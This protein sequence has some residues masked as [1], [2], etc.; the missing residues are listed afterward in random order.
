MPDSKNHLERNVCSVAIM[1]FVIFKMVGVKFG[2]NLFFLF[3]EK[4]SAIQRL[5]VFLKSGV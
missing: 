2:L 1:M 3:L 5:F 4:L